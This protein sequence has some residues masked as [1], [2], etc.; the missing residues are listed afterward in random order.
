MIVL[1]NILRKPTRPKRCQIR[2]ASASAFIPLW[3][4]FQLFNLSFIISMKPAVVP[5]GCTKTR[6]WTRD[7]CSMAKRQAMFAPAPSPNTMVWGIFRW[8]RILINSLAISSNVGYFLEWQPS[9]QERIDSKAFTGETLLDREYSGTILL[10]WQVYMHPHNALFS[11]RRNKQ[12]RRSIAYIA[13]SLTMHAFRVETRT[14]WRPNLETKNFRLLSSTVDRSS[15]LRLHPMSWSV[16]T[17][18][19][20]LLPVSSWMRSRK[21]SQRF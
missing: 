12:R 16:I 19:L 2:C 14:R 20:A 15:F 11:K 5:V 1:K 17:K 10:A 9:R 13:R 6:P 7:G 21:H 3:I 18:H 4:N 8:S